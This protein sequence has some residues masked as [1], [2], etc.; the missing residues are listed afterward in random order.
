VRDLLGIRPKEVRIGDLRSNSSVS[1]VYLKVH[2]SDKCHQE[3][4]P[5]INPVSWMCIMSLIMCMLLFVALIPN[6]VS[7]PCCR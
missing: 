3:R 6:C 4:V 2:M 5:G 1:K 7:N